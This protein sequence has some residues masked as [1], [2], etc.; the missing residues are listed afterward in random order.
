[1]GSY[2]PT[3]RATPD[4]AALGLGFQV[5]VNGAVRDI[6]GTSAS[7]P[8]VGALFSLINDARLAAGKPPMGFANPFIY[9]NAHA[10]TDVTVGTNGAWNCDVGWDP[11]TGLGTP[12]F[13][14][15]L[16]AAMNAV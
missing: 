8:T 6:G 4:V 16:A 5:M 1:M 9:Q 3:N 7:S 14:Q 15:L 13:D 2:D 10:F 12:K 11:V